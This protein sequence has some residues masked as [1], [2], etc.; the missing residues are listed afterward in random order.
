VS[1]GSNIGLLVVD[2]AHRIAA[3]ANVDDLAQRLFDSLAAVAH[4]A[5]KVTPPSCR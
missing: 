3:E 2:E 4:D 5:A 1:E